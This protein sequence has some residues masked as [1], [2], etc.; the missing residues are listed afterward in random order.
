M[1]KKLKFKKFFNGQRSSVEHF[2]EYVLEKM[3]VSPGTFVSKEVFYKL[4]GFIDIYKGKPFDFNGYS[5]TKE[6]EDILADVVA[7]L[8]CY[9]DSDEYFERFNFNIEMIVGKYNIYFVRS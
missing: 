4:A 9:L 6:K 2:C 5:D 8:N 1:N 7:D 3:Q